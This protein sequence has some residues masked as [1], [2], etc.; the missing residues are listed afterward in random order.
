VVARDRAIRTADSYILV[1]PYSVTIA[2]GRR[3][4]I[5]RSWVGA[6][7]TVRLASCDLTLPMLEDAAPCEA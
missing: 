5:A 2:I 7:A 1:S 6:V 4:R 3:F